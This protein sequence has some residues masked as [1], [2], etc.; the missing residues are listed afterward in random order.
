[1]MTVPSAKMTTRYTGHRFSHPPRT[2][3]MTV[4]GGGQSPVGRAARLQTN[5]VK[6][7]TR[8]AANERD[9]I[10]IE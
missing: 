4:P 7:N 3:V 9:M 8:V 10:R 1:M 5:R 6:Q 2:I